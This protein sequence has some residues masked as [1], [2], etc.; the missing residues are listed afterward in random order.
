M[1][2]LTVITPPDGEPVSL[3]SAKAFLRIGHDG[4]DTLVSDLIKRARVRLEQAGGLVLV[5][6]TLRASWSQWPAGIAGRGARLPRTPATELLSVKVIDAEGV[7]TDQTVRFRL[8]CGRAC[9]R[10]WSMV[11]AIPEGGR[12]EVEF[13]AGFG[14][15][16]DVPEDLQEAI[17]RLVGAMYAARV[18]SSFDFEAGGALPEDVQAI[19]DARRGVRL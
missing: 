11:P 12:V 8:D 7:E 1:T 9:L 18:P 15:A 4:E 14:A 2:N 17:L 10:P 3:A 16:T 5:R 19:L 6:Q 13:E